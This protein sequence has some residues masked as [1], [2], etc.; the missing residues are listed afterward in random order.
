MFIRIR[1]LFVLAAAAL[2]SVTPLAGKAQATLKSARTQ[3]YDVR[4]VVLTTGLESPWSL[5]FLPD[6]RM[7]VSERVGRLRILDANGKALAVVS[8]LPKINE[9][10]QGGLLDVVLHPRFASNG[11]VYLS[12]AARGDGGYGTE[13]LRGK[14]TDNRFE[15]VQVIFR[16]QPKSPSGVHFGSRLAFDAQGHL[17]VTLGDR[18]VKE[19]AQRMDDDAGSIVRLNDDGSVPDD[20]PFAKQRGARPELYAK[21]TRNVQGAAVNPET[22]ALWISEHGPQGGDEIDIVRAGANYGWPVVTA[23]VNYGAGSK[24]GEG[25]K[26]GMEAPIHTWTPSIAPAGMAF[27][28]GDRFPQWKGNLLVGALRGRAVVR[29]TLHGDN[30]QSEERMLVNDVGRVR[31]VRVGP[32]GL[33]YLLTDSTDGLLVR[34]EPSQ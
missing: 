1:A 25:Q 22:G 14:L 33:V 7:L 16:M 8:G 19:R 12:Y 15:D 13:V 30:V 10:G 9:F 6:G 17:L 20:N 34:V 23:G 24:I 11:W 4:L 18:G 29:L 27:Y 28:Q 31:D 2:L 21:G 26:P 32:D 5:A 3:L